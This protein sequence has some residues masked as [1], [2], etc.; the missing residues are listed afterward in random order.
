MIFTGDADGLMIVAAH[1]L[2]KHGKR[3]RQLDN[4]CAQ[5]AAILCLLLLI[6][7]GI[8]QG[9][10]GAFGR[11]AV[12]ASTISQ[13]PV[14]GIRRIK[15]STFQQKSASMSAR[16]DAMAPTIDGLLS[17]RTSYDT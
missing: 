4:S 7:V 9:S 6:S 10:V 14:T 16:F 2:F 13:A 12:S 1:A 8:G 15:N 11:H 5:H 17:A 3:A